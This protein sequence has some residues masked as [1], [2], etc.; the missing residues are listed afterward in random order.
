MKT[1]ITILWMLLSTA[2]MSQ[3]LSDSLQLKKLEGLPGHSVYSIVQDS[4]NVIWIS[5][6]KGLV[7]H[8]GDRYKVFN[9][10]SDKE[11][12]VGS[13]Y[14]RFMMLS[15][16]NQIVITTNRDVKIFDIATET[17]VLIDSVRARSIIEDHN[18]NLWWV[19]DNKLR[20]LDY[21]ERL[22]KSYRSEIYYEHLPLSYY[23]YSSKK[24]NS[25]LAISKDHKYSHRF[26]LT[27][28]EVIT[29]PSGLDDNVP[30]P[31]WT[32]TSNYITV[33]TKIYTYDF[34]LE[35]LVLLFDLEDQKEIDAVMFDHIK[36]LDNEEYLAMTTNGDLL[37]IGQQ[38]IIKTWNL[39]A[40]NIAFQATRVASFF[41][42]SEQNIWFTTNNGV[43]IGAHK[44]SIFH[45]I[46]NTSENSSYF[47]ARKIQ[48]KDDSTVLIGGYSG[49][50][51]YNPIT[52][53]HKKLGDSIINVFEI[54]IDSKERIWYGHDEGPISVNE[55]GDFINPRV[56]IPIDAKTT[57][58]IEID[59]NTF[60]AGGDMLF[61]IENPQLDSFRYTALHDHIISNLFVEYL[62]RAKDHSFWVA[63]TT[64]IFQLS[65]DLSEL[66]IWSEVHGDKQ[67]F[68]HLLQLDNGNLLATSYG[69]GL[70]EFSPEG[71]IVRQWNEAN[72]LSSNYLCS[73]LLHNNQCWI[74]SE[75]GLI[76][77]DLETGEISKYDKNSGLS[78]SEYNRNSYAKLNDSTFLFGGIK[79]IDQFNPKDFI[80]HAKTHPVIIN[81]IAITNNKNVSRQD[82]VD[83]FMDTDRKLQISFYCPEYASLE[84]IV[85]QYRINEDEN[86]THLST[87]NEIEF[88]GLP[89]E[90][91]T[92]YLRAKN[93][94]KK[95]SDPSEGIHIY[96][97][98][99]FYRRPSFI[100]AM[101]FALGS[102]ITLYFLYRQRKLQQEALWQKQLIR[103]Y[104]SQVERERKKI[105][106][107]LHDSVGQQLALLK[108]NSK[109]AS[110][111]MA[112]D[113]VISEIRDLSKDLYPYE[114]QKFGFK[115]A[116]SILCDKLSSRS[117]ISFESDLDDFD[118]EMTDEELLLLY[119]II[120]ESFNNVIKHSQAQF[121]MVRYHHEMEA[122]E[123]ID[124]GKGFK[125][126]NIEGLGIKSIQSNANAIS[127]RMSIKNNAKGC[128]IWIRWNQD[129]L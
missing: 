62:L 112:V 35:K 118:R 39:S 124:N 15:R 45:N 14:I 38:G 9:S 46:L 48:M 11:Q 24:Y 22:N 82:E 89:Y 53:A 113:Q 66:N 41:I 23:L 26:D 100:L 1:L 94:N 105:S 67:H 78:Q 98:P 32:E 50:H 128:S 68:T 42:D 111:K 36:A 129:K 101:L 56:V 114:L 54:L 12:F 19:S 86:W 55:S 85:Y 102:L 110:Q 52:K 47:S 20:R 122:L 119:R 127:A 123:I 69:Q 125:N 97:P 25:I 96:D 109:E 90:D 121:A 74:S 117:S 21:S 16:L 91:N 75:K 5:N 6:N 81:Q 115:E 30:P 99:P 4:S 76:L 73:M 106:S 37:H 83:Q 104:Q 87:D 59:S 33:G 72:G 108:L 60:L 17:M 84:E 77:L 2:A 44:K 28:H 126:E 57:S 10:L 18:N 71:K 51:L 3:V 80:S 95:W 79:G 63:T 58:I 27:S 13:Q 29:K 107:L 61:K 116:I 93:Q 31:A 7:R 43:Y 64:G 103:K 49:L 92:I 88:Y 40:N 70:F 8:Q 34:E 120:Q 65:K